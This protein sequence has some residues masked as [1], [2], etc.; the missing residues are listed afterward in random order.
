MTPPR[1][2][3]R[4]AS[5]TQTPLGIRPAN[6]RQIN[7]ALQGGG[8][9]GAF[10]WGVLDRMLEDGRLDIEG[11]SA[12][13]AGAMNAVVYAYGLMTGG[14]EG[15]RAKLEAFW[16]AIS[17][18]GQTTSPVRQ[19]P[20]DVWLR[21]LGMRETIGYHAFE[22]MTRVFSPYQFN[23]L[24]LNPLKDVIVEI[25]DFEE[26]RRCTST[27]LRLCATNVRTGKPKIFTNQTLSADVV[28]ASACLPMLFRAV[29]IEGESYW[30]GGY[31]G[32]PAIFP[33]I[34][35]VEC[36]D[37]LIVHI[38]PII[39]PDVPTTSS[40]IY[41]RINEISFNSSLIREM[42]AIA[43]ATKLI[44]DDWIKPEFRDKMKRLNLHAIRADEVM[45]E[46]TVASK[47]D[48]DWT[49]LTHLRDMG[50]NAAA[51]WLDGHFQDI[52]E[53]S[54]VDIRAEYL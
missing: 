29:E 37:I 38:N 35:D 49:F 8:A 44:D 36:R 20:I 47:F 46:F 28:L 43:F 2:P 9:H 14:R 22:T 48:T 13:S 21:A 52:G 45:S 27:A 31:I 17:E 40:D 6:T 26:L 16:R 11:I 18:R 41:N 33:L 32:N 1:T 23:P 12:T 24:N 54:T 3:Y 15:A 30:D 39:R 50:R 19:T 42:R 34:Y 25:V 4:I 53:R 51:L 7:L 10:G 5:D